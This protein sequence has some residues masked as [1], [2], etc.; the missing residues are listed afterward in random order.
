MIILD[1]LD[2]IYNKLNEGNVIDAMYSYF[3]KVFDKIPHSRLAANLEIC[4]IEGNVFFRWI[5]KLAGGQKT[6]GI[7]EGMSSGQLI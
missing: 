4:E 2:E 3:A 7:I 1:C 5:K 6:E